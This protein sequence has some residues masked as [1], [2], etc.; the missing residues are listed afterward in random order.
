M[1]NICAKPAAVDS[2]CFFEILLLLGFWTK[3]CLQ[4]VRS[5]YNKHHINFKTHKVSNQL[6]FQ[7]GY[8][9]VGKHL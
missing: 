5:K 8:S 7:R 2:V 6:A 1:Q 3:I 4:M 9:P